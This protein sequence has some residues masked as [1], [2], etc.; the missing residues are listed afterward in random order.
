MN[1]SPL[2]DPP[3]KN[4]P[5]LMMSLLVVAVFFSMAARAIFAPLMPSLQIE[6]GISLSTVGLLFLLV[7]VSYAASMLFVGFLAARI[8]H[9]RTIV[10]ALALITLGL[11]VS[12]LAPGSLLLAAGMLCIG[13]GAGAYP[14]SGLVMINTKISARR[15]STAFAIHEI[16]PNMALLLSPL[17]VLAME[18]WIGWRGILVW[19]AAVC[20]VAALAFLR[21]GAADSG[22][23]TAPD[24]STMGRILTWRS[25][26]VGMVLFSAML[27]A[28][29]GV[30]AI[31]PAYLVTEYAL[32]PQY[33]NFLLTVSRISSVLFLLF[34]GAIIGR[35]GRRRVIL[36][37]LLITSVFIA[38]IGLVRGPWIALVVV[39]Q[40][41]FLTILIPA[42]LSAVADIGE[43]RYQNITYAVIITVGV[44][45]GAGVVPALLGLCGDFGLGWL[46]F[47]ALAGYMVA[48][49]LFLLATPGF[50]K[51]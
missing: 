30:Y 27:A 31:L 16:G 10:V 17:I 13:A 38:L 37:N 45:V 24:L 32:S 36:W 46:G 28:L 26:W 6:M 21:W 48:A 25:T 35:F 1:A 11:L 19:M 44:S 8:G 2:S 9:G 29:H 22:M 40:P 33:V 4:R 34:A 20:A 15:R 7:S 42:L 18:P 3:G 39:A 14:P 51:D 50:G 47:V 43:T 49:I 5:I 23:G 41:T 12:A